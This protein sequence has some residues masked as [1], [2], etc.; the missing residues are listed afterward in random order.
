M[1]QELRV[2]L[3][4]PYGKQEA[5]LVWKRGSEHMRSPYWAGRA[6]RRIYDV[7]HPRDP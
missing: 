7:A 3:P 1:S 2:R 6:Q 5:F 4:K